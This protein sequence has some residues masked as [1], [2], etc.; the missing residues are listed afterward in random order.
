MGEP[1]F[2]TPAIANRTLYV[3]TRGHLYGIAADER[4][5]A[6]WPPEA[7]AQGEPAQGLVL[8]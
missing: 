1:V 3:R 5:A 7:G 8:N 4:K 2:A 6:G